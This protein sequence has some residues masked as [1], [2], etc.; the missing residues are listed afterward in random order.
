[1]RLGKRKLALLLVLIEQHSRG[2]LGLLDVG[3]VE[4]IDVE[5][6]TSSRGGDLPAQELRAE[7]H[8]VGHLERSVRHVLDSETVDTRCFLRANRH[9]DDDAIVTELEVSGLTGDR[10]DAFA[11]LARALGDELLHPE[12]ERLQLRRNPERQLVATGQGAGAHESTERE[13]GVLTG[14]LRLDRPAPW[15]VRAQAMHRCRD[16]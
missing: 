13:T 1:M 3:L 9:A 7:R 11:V 15:R 16:P 10:H 5:Q 12:T 8:E 6:Q 4:R 2:V 14:A